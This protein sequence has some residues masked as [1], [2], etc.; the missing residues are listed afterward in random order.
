MNKNEQNVNGA[1]VEPDLGLSSSA[2]LKEN[3]ALIEKLEAAY[4]AAPEKTE[5][6]SE[7]QFYGIKFNSLNLLIDKN[8]SSELLE[9]SV[10]YP[11]PLAADW[12]IGVVNI[13]GDII[14]VIDFEK[15][16][17]GESEKQTTDESKIIIIN[18]GE[19]AIGF[20]INHLPRPIGFNDDEKLSGHSTLPKV[21]QEHVDF[22][23]KKEATTWA[24]IDF[25]SFIQ[26]IKLQ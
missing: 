21:V 13:R 20:M 25:E 4:Q 17:C 22:A 7:N 9:D 19:D 5:T 2:W 24:R 16:I 18:K 11:I 8:I 3:E 1:N 15:L 10:V 14:P 23:F 6:N 12:I 26:S